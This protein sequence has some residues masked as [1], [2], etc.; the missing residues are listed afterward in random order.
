MYQI[1][2]VP[3]TQPVTTNRHR[4]Q[5]LVGACKVPNISFYVF[6]LLVADDDSLLGFNTI[7]RYA[8]LSDISVNNGGPIRL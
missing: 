5:A 6:M 2:F 7:Y 4:H 3:V 8:P 1:Y